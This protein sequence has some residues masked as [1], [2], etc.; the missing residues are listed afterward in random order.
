MNTAAIRPG[1]AKAWLLAS[2]LPTLAAAFVPVAVGTAAA[3]RAGG[4]AWLPAIAALLAA[5]FIQ[6]GTNFANDVFD[7]E[8]G[9]DTEHRLGP[10]RTA[11]AGL[12]TPSQL[13]KGIAVVF[14]LAMAL[15]L[16][17]TWVGGPVILA[18]G[19]ASLLAGLAYTGGP[20]PLAYNGLGDVFVIVFFG[21]VA[22]C[23]TA[24]VQVHS[25]PVIAVFA[26]VPVGALATNILVVNNVRDRETDARAEKRTLIVRFGRRF[27][28]LEYV[29]LVALAYGTPVVLYVLHLA[30]ILVLLPLLTAPLAFRLASRLRR[31]SG[32]VLNEVLVGTAKTMMLFGI[33]FALGL[34]LAS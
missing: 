25:V 2:R 4:I 9:A 32:A 15:G 22:V 28:E 14:G 18:I 10:V 11:Q 13:K 31:E 27:G 1:S 24:F 12:I 23:G 7:Y 8:K 5:C 33:L 29:V 26:A 3:H 19:I 6:I 30:G 16:Y 34:A 20:F 21:F 17:L